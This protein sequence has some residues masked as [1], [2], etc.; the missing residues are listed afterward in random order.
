M[1]HR[2]FPHQVYL[3]ERLPP[4][5]LAALGGV[6]REMRETCERA[7]EDTSHLLAPCMHVWVP[8]IAHRRSCAAY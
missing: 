5:S 2:P 6:S 1:N 7:A 4:E 8:R 3:L